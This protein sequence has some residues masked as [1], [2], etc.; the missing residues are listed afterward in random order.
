METLGLHLYEA[1]R[2]ATGDKLR[3]IYIYYWLY[4]YNQIIRRTNSICDWDRNK[5]RGAG[6]GGYLEHL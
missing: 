6:A 5:A 3:E 4:G 1:M 2:G